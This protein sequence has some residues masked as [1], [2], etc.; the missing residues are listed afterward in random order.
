[1]PPLLRFARLLGRQLGNG[2]QWLPWIHTADVTHAIQFL[3]EHHTLSGPFNL[4]APMPATHQEFM[5]AMRRVLRRPAIF[6]LPAWALRVAL[7][8]MSRVVLDSQR[9]SP[10]RLLEAGFQFN[11]PQLDG[12]LC[13]LLSQEHTHARGP[14]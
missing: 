10:Q 11:Y 9:M 5:H 13:H 8:E 4:C 7:G 12:A 3:L 6:T 2:Q 1:L 14:A